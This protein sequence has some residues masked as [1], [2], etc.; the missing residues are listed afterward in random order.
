[1]KGRGKGNEWLLI[2][3]RDAAAVPGW[4]VE[5]HATSVLSGRT[6]QE[7]AENLPARKEKRKAA[8]ATDRTWDSSRPARAPR[9]APAK[10]ATSSVKKN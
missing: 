2:K 7:I 3:K 6:Q 8:G 10:S 9:K 4:E 1:M 5:D